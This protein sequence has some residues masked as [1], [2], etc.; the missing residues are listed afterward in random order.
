M[1]PPLACARLVT[2]RIR[3]AGRT[4]RARSPDHQSY[5]PPGWRAMSQW[6]GTGWGQAPSRECGRHAERNTAGPRAGS[7]RTR[8]CASRY[9]T[10]P[11]WRMILPVAGHCPGLY[12]GDPLN[13]DP[14]SEQGVE[15]LVWTIA[16]D[17]HQRPQ[18]VEL[19]P[20]VNLTSRR[21]GV[22]TEWKAVGERACF[23]A[24][25]RDPLER[26]P[27]GWYEITGSMSAREDA[28]V[29]PCLYPVYARGADGEARIALPTSGGNGRIRA[30]VLF[31]HDVTALGFSMGR[32]PLRFRMGDF[33]VRRI[34]RVRALRRMLESTADAPGGLASRSIRFIRQSLR[35]GVSR[36]A[37]TL[38]RD[39]RRRVVP[40]GADSYDGWVARFDTL[41]AERMDE[42]RC[43][44]IAITPEG[45]L[46]SILLPVYQTPERW[47][48]R[49]IESVLDQAYSKWQLCIV[50]DASPNP[51]VM[52]IV[53]EYAQTDFRI[54]VMRR[55]RNG[56]IS[57]AS[58]SALGLASGDYVS[59]LDHDDELRPHALLEVAEEIGR[60]PDAG[61]LYSDEDK[62]DAE[63]RRFDPYFKP[64]FDSDLLRSQN[65]ICHLTTIR[66]EL[67]REVGGFRKG[68]EGSQDHDLILRCVERLQPGQVRHIPKVLYH[69]RAIP[70]STAL[71]RDAKDYASSAG[72]RA[73][74][75]HLD[76][77]HPGARAEELSHGHYRVHWPLPAIPPK[78]SLIIPTRDKVELL[79]MCVESIV[80]K[81]T[82]PDYEIVVVDNQ[83]SEPGA[84]AYLAELEGRE[85]VMVLRYDAAFNYAAINNW[86]ASQCA[87][88][89]IGLVNNDIEVISPEW[90]EELVSQAMRPDVGAVGAM[91]YYP[92]DTI[93][94][95][96][97][98]LG[99][100][101]VAA[102]IYSGLPRGYPGHGG[103]ARVAQSLS[104]VTGACLMVRREVFDQVGGLD[105]QLQ[106]AF[107]DIDFCLRV[108]EAGYRNIWTPFA[109]LYHHESASRG[110][111]D[112]EE[113]KQR[114]AR[115]VDL[116]RQRWGAQLLRDPAYNVNLSLDSL[117][118]ELSA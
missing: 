115:E 99:I 3:S 109:E 67:M 17:T 29:A 78:V 59:L 80:S 104:A 8:A 107:N 86:A 89:V 16:P 110:S 44:A 49:C 14:N 90:L 61:L 55:D 1:Q 82:Y 37:D 117:V 23:T 36:A 47:L 63:G 39:Y 98:V 32:G 6:P 76:R 22:F 18:T 38:Y 88:E 9:A 57:E 65:Y 40:A 62:I 101:G 95:A 42:L 4:E 69:W 11:D 45:R 81:T 2:G 7:H 91:L 106:V 105:E 103:R 28:V 31:K 73:V 75:G 21:D 64:D 26:I 25:L 97:V 43:R 48:R 19:V 84:L 112:T 53:Q 13:P 77:Q 10:Q 72:A 58:N 94:H 102:H 33:A 85:R 100:H 27:A 51:R 56:H 15:A 87:G 66:A 52:E 5:R 113:K 71:T 46:I 93:Q 60:H 30:L 50:D 116:M 74:A 111:E 41:T 12:V 20:D 114:F 34:A 68:F 24:E 118:C 79:R 70:G 35:D 54:R 108:R 92:N 96:G 83:S